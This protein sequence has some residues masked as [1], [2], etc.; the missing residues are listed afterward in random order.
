MYFVTKVIL[1][2]VIFITL[3]KVFAVDVA[4]FLVPS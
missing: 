3:D 1:L 4:A 2:K